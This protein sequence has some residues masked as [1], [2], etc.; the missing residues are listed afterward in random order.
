MYIV[1]MP[2]ARAR[3]VETESWANQETGELR[4][5]DVVVVSDRYGKIAT[6]LKFATA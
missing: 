1:P 4:Y 5:K 6:S 3:Q 2:R